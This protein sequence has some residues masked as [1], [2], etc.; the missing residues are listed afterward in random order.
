MVG[1]LGLDRHLDFWIF[2]VF[3]KAQTAP[4]QIRHMDFEVNFSSLEQ[5]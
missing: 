1:E 3:L 4:E 2:S 5:F